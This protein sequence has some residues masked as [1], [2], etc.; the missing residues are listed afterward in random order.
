MRAVRTALSTKFRV[1]LRGSVSK[2]L[3]RVGRLS[4]KMG[5]VNNVGIMRELMNL[6]KR[7]KRLIVG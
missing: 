4:L 6:V 2:N 1:K 7:V 5:H 3:V